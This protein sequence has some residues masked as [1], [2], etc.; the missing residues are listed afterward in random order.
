MEKKGLSWQL[1]Q[2]G[3][4]SGTWTKLLAASR[5]WVLAHLSQKCCLPGVKEWVK[6]KEIRADVNVSTTMV[7]DIEL[8]LCQPRKT[9]S[10]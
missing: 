10:E 3:L 5:S 2:V 4:S 9:Q 8:E 1:K 6:G 7:G